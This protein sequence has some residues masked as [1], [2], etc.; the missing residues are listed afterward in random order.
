[1]SKGF[2]KACFGPLTLLNKFIKKD[3][4]LVFFYSNMGFRDNVRAVYDYMMEHGYNEEYRIVCA[5][6]EWEEYKM[7]KKYLPERYKNVKFVS[8]K[9]GILKFLRAKYAFYSFGKYPIKPSKEQVVVNVWH[10]MPLKRIGN[11]EKGKEKVKYNYFTYILATSKLF[12][13]I[14]MKSFS[15]SKEQVIINGQ[16]RN[17][18]MFKEDKELD[19][20]IRMGASKFIFWLPTYRK[21]LRAEE[22]E[23]AIDDLGK[24]KSPI[25]LLKSVRGHDFDALLRENN[26]QLIVKHHPLHMEDDI[27]Y[28]TNI[29]VFSHKDFENAGC[30][31]Y[32]YLRNAD[33]LITDY[34]SVYFDYLLLDR[35]IGF[36]LD[37]MND[38]NEERGFVFDNPLDMMP[39]AHIKT[40]KDLTEFV[41]SVIEGRDEYADKRRQFNDMVNQYQDG[42]ST[43]QLLDR[44]MK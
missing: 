18:V 36:V 28:F 2:L 24:Q 6:D 16:P 44:I 15:C 26:V 12:A 1:M 33:A 11:M 22:N 34:S 5:I 43:K 29:K 25:D 3:E 13:D 7:E 40:E 4:K 39:G 8:L 17:D 14:M 35:P 23:Y 27:G 38:Y 37:D 32:S 41:L 20:R 21:K 42:N 19:E 30:D 31:L 9:G 10:G